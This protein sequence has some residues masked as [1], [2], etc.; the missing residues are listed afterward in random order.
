MKPPAY[1][2]DVKQQSA[3]RWEVLLADRG[4]V[5]PW[6]LL[7]KQ[8]TQS[9]RHVLSELLQNA[10]DAHA[11]EASVRITGLEF[12]FSHNGEDF[13]KDQFQSLCRFAFSNK[14]AL[15]TIGFRGIGFKSTFSLGDEVRVYS[16]TLAV[17]FH[18][19]RFTD[20]QWLDDL[21][22]KNDLT[23]IRITIKNDSLKNE[24]E[25]NFKEWVESPTSLLFFK[26]ITCLTIN[27]QTIKW[28]PQGDG[29]ISNSRWVSM[30]GTP[31]E[32][33]LHVTSD[34]VDFP[35]ESLEEIR[36]ETMVLD[37]ET[38]FPPA[39]VEIVLGESGRLFV[40][41]PTGVKTT[42]PFAC[43][44]PFIQDPAREKII[45]PGASPT[46]QW[47]L[48]RIGTL[49]ADSLLH[50]VNR[51]DLPVSD[52]CQSYGLWPDVDREDNSIEGVCATAVE[53]AFS[54]SI[55]NQRCLISENNTIELPK[56]C[57]SIPEEIREIWDAERISSLF[58][59]ECRPVLS[60]YIS[61]SY[62]ERLEHWGFVD[63][64]SKE[65]IINVLESKQIPK[66][67]TWYQL[68]LL[69]AYVADEVTRYYSPH[70]GVHIVPIQGETALQ[71]ASGI[72]RLGEKQ[73]LRS[74]E[75]WQFLSNYLITM[76]QNYFNYLDK[77]RHDSE[78]RQNEELGEKVDAAYR[79]LRS[80][81]LEQA[82]D[83]AKIFEETSSKFFSQNSVSRSDCVRLAHIAATLG[84]TVKSSFKFVTQ[85]NILHNINDGVV[86]DIGDLDLFSTE[87][88]YQTH[89][90]HTDYWKPS[91][92]CSSEEWSKWVQSERSQLLTFVS[93]EQKTRRIYGDK[94]LEE[95]LK[96]RGFLSNDNLYFRYNTENYYTNDWDFNDSH[97]NQWEKLAKEDEK[98]WVRVLKRLFEQPARCWAKFVSAKV[99]QI[100]KNGYTNS[101]T[102]EPIIPEWI[103]KFRTL[104]CIEDTRGI[105]CQPAALLRR[106]DL[107]LALLGV[108]DFVSAEIDNEENRPLLQLL[109][110]RDTP[111]GPG[112]LLERLQAL[113]ATDTP[114]LHEVL[115]WYERLDQVASK[116]D[117]D[118]L[119]FIKE[120]FEKDKITLMETDGQTNWG[121][122]GEV[123]LA[124]DED[125]VPGASLVHSLVRHLSIW[126]KIGV[127]T[128]P[129]AETAIEWLKTLPSD[130]PLSA[131]DARRVRALLPRYPER[132]WHECSH[133]VDLEGRWTPVSNFEYAITM[134]SLVLYSHL[135]PFFK[136]KTANFQSLTEEQCRQ[137]PFSD[138]PHLAT[139]IKDQFKDS[140]F[141]VQPPEEKPWIISLGECLSRI[142]LGNE[143]ETN[144]IRQLGRR[145][146]NTTWQITE[147]L[148]VIPYIAGKPAGTPR[149]IPTFWQDTTLYV[150]K[151]SAGK[152]AKFVPEE[153]GTAFDN[154]LIKEAI[155]LCYDRSPVFI[156]EY[157]EENFKLVSKDE[158]TPE[159]T[160]KI[161][162]AEHPSYEPTKTTDEHPDEE[163]V[164]LRE[165]PFIEPEDEPYEEPNLEQEEETGDGK[166][167]ELET[168]Q[169]KSHRPTKPELIERF[170]RISGFFLNG[171]GK[172]R[173]REGNCLEPAHNI[174]FNWLMRDRT[175]QL[176]QY[177]WVKDHCLEDKPLEVDVP[178]WDLCEK[179]P[180]LYSF[181]IVDKQGQPEE[182]SGYRLTDMKQKGELVVH[183]A[184][185]RLVYKENGS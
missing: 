71:S 157:M 140:L 4:L 171:S 61:D 148:E 89:V 136:Q 159:E 15:H 144:R 123:Y 49:A 137:Q 167:V 126:H 74:Q 129:T 52:R 86:A 84:V 19:D 70:K 72:V 8:V 122:L 170:A 2:Q 83:T 88:W 176:I 76:N 115:K 96:S 174:G 165:E 68:M 141:V 13:D 178:I 173:D 32:R 182:V 23:E 16:P 62:R 130:S 50:W 168:R 180:E 37:E 151:Q 125:A 35:P 47:L 78:V 10:D 161:F 91:T 42:L 39:R 172:Y 22:S 53:M 46:N 143:E 3:K 128:R 107:T 133:W 105:P 6:Y 9:P 97:W 7:F 142:L 36:K 166:E 155:M 152:L 81:G 179:S 164:I 65:N 146:S 158:I 60:Q 131:A 147:V 145:L 95:F 26:H 113:S 102:S 1:F 87:G 63:N 98:Y 51:D 120:S 149:R 118:D 138:I 135:F 75:D 69:W 40:V 100:A 139:H 30:E 163:A 127:T 20:P 77:R 183:P 150:A 41:L 117:T 169:S 67:G 5:G 177:Y 29:P 45:E 134:Q 17:S 124:P 112:K 104:P 14:R 154:T 175:G 116:C 111:T 44:A 162:E 181:I 24:V 92:S 94:K 38:V 27:G 55:E 11:T 103:A 33:F 31:N 108:D 34:E 109:G 90:L 93:L 18:K 153:L 85:D 79:V 57:I 185:Y 121:K 56:G 73:L 43:N 28:V 64:I 66:P 160:E 48:S 54:K 82:S 99:Y 80:I 132:I 58:D 101:I 12:I 114:P 110:V 59:A 156:T 25:K 21:N 119:A 184:S 106:T